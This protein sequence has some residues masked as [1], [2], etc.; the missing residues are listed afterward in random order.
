MKMI[1]IVKIE[2][3]GE[4]TLFGIGDVMVERKGGDV[5]WTTTRKE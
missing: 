5:P 4:I 1:H 2:A 3:K